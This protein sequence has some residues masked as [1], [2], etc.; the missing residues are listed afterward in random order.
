MEA[1]RRQTVT[2]TPSTET[3]PPHPD[4]E[5][6]LSQNGTITRYVD[7]GLRMLETAPHIVLVGK[8]AT[9]NKTVTVA[10]IIKRRKE[11]QLYQYTQIGSVAATETWD[12]VKEALD[13]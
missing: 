1:Y 2:S 8:G 11:G 6:H 12:P 13:T 4:N 5:I 10:E 9:V 7:A 3:T